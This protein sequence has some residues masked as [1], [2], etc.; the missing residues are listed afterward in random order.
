[1]LAD[2]FSEVG[3]AVAEGRDERRHWHE[4]P[5]VL[6]ADAAVDRL[7]AVGEV[8]EE[9][10]VVFL[11]VGVAVA[12]RAAHEGDVFLEPALGVPVAVALHKR[13]QLHREFG[14]EGV[15]PRLQ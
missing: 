1:M 7:A 15:L 6:V 8:G 12:P 5:D 13:R 4:P 11:D 2:Y 3:V 9:V 10:A 14:V